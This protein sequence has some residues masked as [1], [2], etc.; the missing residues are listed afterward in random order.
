MMIM[1]VA[2][3]IKCWDIFVQYKALLLSSVIKHNIFSQQ[4]Y[5]MIY[6]YNSLKMHYQ[7]SLKDFT[8]YKALFR[9]QE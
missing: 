5:K 8:Y 4:M 6:L 7:S 3:P 9:S 1:W 2:Q